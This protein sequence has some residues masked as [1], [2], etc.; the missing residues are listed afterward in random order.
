MS[1]E[2]RAR[3]LQYESLIS[4][5]HLSILP[6]QHAK[7]AG[8]THFQ[9]AGLP[10]RAFLHFLGSAH[11]RKDAAAFADSVP[12]ISWLDTRDKMNYQ[13]SKL[14]VQLPRTTHRPSITIS[15]SKLIIQN[16]GSMHVQISKES[17]VTRVE[18]VEHPEHELNKMH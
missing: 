18:E 7:R 3:N 1:S 13:F 5:C 4:S 9:N 14:I 2:G 15:V 6:P 16:N 17:I 11:F 12:W 10:W 8:R